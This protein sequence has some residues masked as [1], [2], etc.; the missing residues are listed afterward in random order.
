M[1]HLKTATDIL[2]RR[3]TFLRDHCTPGTYQHAEM[4]ALRRVML[5]VAAGGPNEID[6]ENAARW[7]RE[8]IKYEEAK[9]RRLRKEKQT[10]FSY[11][12]GI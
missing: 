12:E 2:E 1:M 5:F 7:W 9:K 3:Y 4:T 8:A 6:Q 11:G 10:F